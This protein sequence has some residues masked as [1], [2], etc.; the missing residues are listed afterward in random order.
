MPV[1]N[2]S[3]TDFCSALQRAKAEALQPVGLSDLVITVSYN[4]SDNTITITQ[5]TRFEYQ[6]TIVSSA[7]LQIG[8]N[9]RYALSKDKIN[10]ING[11]IRLGKTSYLL[12]NR[13]PYVSYLDL[14]TIRNVY[15]ESSSLAN[16]NTI[17]NFGN[18]V[19]IKKI[20]VKSNFSQMLFDNADEVYDFMDVSKRSMKS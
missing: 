16:Y 12:G 1:G 17:S 11:I 10:S 9:W 15:I 3:G 14:H 7:D 19:I 18:D 2:Y 20:S 13:L 4:L 8:K 6:V 5:T